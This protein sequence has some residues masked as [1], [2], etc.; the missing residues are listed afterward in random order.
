M[1]FTIHS[2]G[3][4]KGPMEIRGQTQRPIPGG[5]WGELWKQ[6]TGI[7]SRGSCKH[8]QDNTNVKNKKNLKTQSTYLVNSNIPSSPHMHILK[9]ADTWENW[10]KIPVVKLPVKILKDDLNPL[11]GF[12]CHLLSISLDTA[13]I[14][15]SLK[16]FEGLGRV[17]IIG[18]EDKY[19]FGHLKCM[20][21]HIH[22]QMSFASSYG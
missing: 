9:I 12:T 4:V 20:D 1:P 11:S 14:L 8:Y 7:E 2:Q 3:R 19:K 21:T 22:T 17:Y 5:V 18:N 16:G 13:S 10:R 6:K 15:F